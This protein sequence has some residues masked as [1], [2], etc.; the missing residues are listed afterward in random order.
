M[1]YSWV[2][3]KKTGTETQ[4][5][6]ANSVV[7]PKPKSTGFLC[8]SSILDPMKGLD[9]DF[10]LSL[11]PLPAE[12]LLLWKHFLKNVHPL[13]MIFFDWE[14][15]I[16]IRRASHDPA[17]L[18]PGDQ[19][20]VLAI[21]FITTLSLSEEQCVEQLHCNRIQLLE[22]Y[23]QAVEQSLLTAE[24]LVTSDRVV[25]QAFMLYLVNLLPLTQ[26]ALG[27]NTLS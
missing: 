20:L 24:F 19:A 11:H 27:T 18:T 9:A 4:V 13:I 2:G 10:L 1:W 7:S 12:G 6:S 17:M 16:I 3:A 22:R 26:L 25:L 14:V 21:Y 15:E 23:Q 8:F 5:S